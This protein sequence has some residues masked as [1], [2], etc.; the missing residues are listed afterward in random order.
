MDYDITFF[1]PCRSGSER[2]I[3]KNTKDFAGINGGLLFLK[4][5]QLLELKYTINIILSTN[6]NK[7]IEIGKSFND[8]RIT[9]DERPESLC[10][11]ST[12]V[13]DLINY[14]PKIVK[15]SHVFWLHVTTP[16]VGPEIYEDA[17]S[18]YFLKLEEGFDSIMS[19]SKCNSFLWDSEKRETINF[20]RNHGYPRTQD[21]KGLYEINHAFYAMSI[22]NYLRFKDRIGTNPYLYQLSK[23]NGFDIDEED[24]FKISEQIFKNKLF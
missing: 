20:D 21:L 8:S 5:K 11:S 24:D 22:K 23:V 1:L 12:K 14:V 15:T 13:K 17:I 4:L 7:V 16:F 6:D 19:V 2:V 9:I 18:K 10:L 3:D